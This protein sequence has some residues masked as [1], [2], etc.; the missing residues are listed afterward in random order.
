MPLG[1]RTAKS[2]GFHFG[3]TMIENEHDVSESRSDQIHASTGTEDPL[4]NGF[5]SDEWDRFIGLRRGHS[6]VA[7]AITVPIHK[8]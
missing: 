4:K 7:R 2:T 8:T 3:L 1:V 5:A 6:L